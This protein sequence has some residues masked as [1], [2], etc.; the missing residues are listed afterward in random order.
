MTEVLDAGA[1]L[2]IDRG[3]KRLMALVLKERLAG[4]SAVTHGGIVGQA[5]RSGGPKQ[6]R[7]A[8]ALPGIEV[9]PLDEEF[10]K[11]A[12][13]LLAAAR[14]ADVIDAAAVLLARHGDRIWTSDP[15]DLAHLAEAARLRVDIVKV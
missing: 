8:K 13:R 3:D 6:A 15:T 1:L 5:W 2:R 11:R 9:V 7:L 10:G 14:S 12:G 4:R